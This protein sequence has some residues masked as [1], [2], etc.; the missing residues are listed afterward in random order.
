MIGNLSDLENLLKS[1]FANKLVTPS[2]LPTISWRETGQTTNPLATLVLLHGISSGSASW[3]EVALN[4]TKLQPEIRVLAW[5]MPGYGK[6]SPF[7]RNEITT[8]DYIKA[9]QESLTAL[10]VNNYIL[11]G[12]SLG[13]LI[14]SYVASTPHPSQ[15]ITHLVLISPAKGYGASDVKEQQHKV[16]NQRLD[17]LKRHG[18]SGL[19]ENIDKRLASSQTSELKRM[20]LRKNTHQI[21]PQ[22]YIHAVD[23]LCDG[24]L[25]STVKKI[26][27]DTSIIVGI[28]DIITTPKQCFDIA[29]ALNANYI[30]V[31]DAG[32]AVPVEQPLIISNQIL[33]FIKD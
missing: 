13:A 21:Q 16:R 19:A 12:H 29:Q 11:V 6:S 30:T 28:Q 9:V 5:D 27:V 8:F 2:N 15:Q 20:W 33:S 32:H 17:A 4:I 14:A 22:G 1:N 23:L 3:L 25:L 7:E 18:I 24:D 10:N 31:D 26:T